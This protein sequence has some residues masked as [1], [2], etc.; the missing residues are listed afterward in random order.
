MILKCFFVQERRK[1]LLKIQEKANYLREL[2]NK[3]H[4]SLFLCPTVIRSKTFGFMF[5]Q[6]L[7]I[8]IRLKFSKKKTPKVLIQLM[9][10]CFGSSSIEISAILYAGINCHTSQGVFLLTGQLCHFCWFRQYVFYV[11][12]IHGT[13]IFFFERL[14]TAVLRVHVKTFI[15]SDQEI[16]R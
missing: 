2:E 5:S 4:F 10:Y 1:L 7:S 15:L 14:S 3:V 12:S 13:N 6:L 8:A 9:V 16:W 11:F